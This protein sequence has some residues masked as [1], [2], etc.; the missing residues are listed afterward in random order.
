MTRRFR[1]FKERIFGK[2]PRHLRMLTRQETYQLVLEEL[3][4]P[5]WLVEVLRPVMDGLDWK[6]RFQEYPDDTG[7]YRFWALEN[8]AG[9]TAIV[10]ITADVLGEAFGRVANFA[11]QMARMKLADRLF[12]FSDS[13]PPSTEQMAEK[14]NWFPGGNVI[15]C[16][17]FQIERLRNTTDPG[18]RKNLVRNWFD[19]PRAPG[20]AS[21]S[22]NAGPVTLEEAAREALVNVLARSSEKQIVRTRG[23]FDLLLTRS[24]L[25]EPWIHDARMKFVDSA[26]INA[27]ILVDMALAEGASGA[28]EGYTVIGHILN[29]ALPYLPSLREESIVVALIQLNNLFP[30]AAAREAL[31]A[32]YATAIAP[33]GAAGEWRKIGPEFVWFG[34]DE[35]EFQSYELPAPLLLLDDLPK[36]I[37]QSGSI[38]LI[39]VESLPGR[40]ATGFLVAPDLVLTNCHVLLT[41]MDMLDGP[42]PDEARRNASSVRFRFRFVR[43][44]PQDAANGIVFHIAAKD[45]IVKL[46]TTRRLDYALLRM[47]RPVTG[48]RGLQP[49][50]Y[51]EAWPSVRSALHIVQHPEGGAMRVDFNVSG[52]T[53]VDTKRGLMQYVTHTRSGSS[54]SPC[55][56]SEWK[57]VGLHHAE[58]GSGKWSKR[59]GIVL[60]QIMNEIRDYIPKT[61]TQMEAA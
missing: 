16:L 59:E 15:F 58:T 24:G 60:L 22:I 25:Q 9:C 21:R 51:V 33:R 29:L 5:D 53:A 18:E 11:M 54:G 45:P 44:D 38:C 42:Q 57:V 52:V 36:C 19:V 49:A 3:P 8:P 27:R 34:P 47:E 7:V 31:L 43:G 14:D 26:D 23:F 20:T 46:S 48:V 12:L 4:L 10:W 30:G 13:A 37:E 39:T 1:A 40:T 6:F 2:P 61:S 50:Q 17:G 32:K 41:D 28:P 56:N 55:F 35:V